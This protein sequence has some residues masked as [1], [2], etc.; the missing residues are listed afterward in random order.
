M[1]WE[2][3][4][5]NTGECAINKRN[6]IRTGTLLLLL[7]LLCGTWVAAQDEKNPLEGADFKTQLPPL[8]ALG[9]EEARQAVQTRPGF[10]LQLVAAEPLV[11]DPIAMA[12]DENSNLFVVEF[13]GVQPQTCR[14]ENHPQGN[15]P[16]V[17]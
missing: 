6:G 3:F 2:L 17:S 10:R 13:P 14:L 4:A 12:F 11:R 7:L 16:N 8:K 1:A 15:C 5:V 9:R